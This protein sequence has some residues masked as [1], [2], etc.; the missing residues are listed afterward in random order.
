MKLS[1]VTVGK[2]KD[3]H[4]SALCSDYSKRIGRYNPL[5]LIEVK[6]ARGESRDRAP[7]LE[8]RRLVDKLPSGVHVVTLDEHGKQ[9]TSVGFSR[10]L[11][12]GSGPDGPSASCSVGPGGSARR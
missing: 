5:S 7:T 3:R 8:A 11:R 6:D 10:W 1:L 2:L 12:S 4:V 9:R